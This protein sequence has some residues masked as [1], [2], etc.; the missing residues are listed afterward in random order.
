MRNM[1]AMCAGHSFPAS[2]ITRSSGRLAAS[3][4]SFHVC[5]LV[6]MRVPSHSTSSNARAF[7]LRRC[8]LRRFPLRSLALALAFIVYPRSRP[9]PFAP[10]A[11]VVLLPFLRRPSSSLGLSALHRAQPPKRERSTTT[12]GLIFHASGDTSSLPNLVP[13]NVPAVPISAHR[14]YTG[15]SSPSVASSLE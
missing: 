15:S 13:Y 14:V 3:G 11:L 10:L 7:W 1:T 12:N 2:T 5:A 6:D 4:S 8:L 9:V